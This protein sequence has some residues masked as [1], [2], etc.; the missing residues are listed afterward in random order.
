MEEETV[1]VPGGRRVEATLSRPSDVD[2]AALSACVVACPPHPE[3]GGNRAD[4]RLRTVTG[5]LDEAR[6]ASLC[7]DYGPWD[8]GYGEREDARN[9]LRWAAERS[10]HVAAFGYS[11][12]AA[13][14][15]L[16]V[17][18]I[19]VELDGVS[20]LAPTATVGDELDAAATLSDITCP[21]QVVYG[22]RDTTAAWQPVVEA[23][24]E[25]GAEVVGLAVDHHFVGQ[26]DKIRRAVVPFLT[27][28]LG[29]G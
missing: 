15:A 12:G 18:T 6:I 28:A 2:P 14:A 25:A 5:G 26:R 17:A 29:V 1:L 20:L 4:P 22:D 11:F 24:R 10:E 21:T 23:A 3:L 13:I 7:F 16:A 27:D 9:A 19:D 8:E